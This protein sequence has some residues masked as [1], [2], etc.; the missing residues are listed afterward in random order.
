[1]SAVWIT[2]DT[3]DI[4][5]HVTTLELQ[6]VVTDYI[7]ETYGVSVKEVTDIERIELDPG[8]MAFFGEAAEYLEFELAGI[9]FRCQHV[10][11][12][13]VLSYL[14]NGYKVVDSPAGQLVKIYF[15]YSIVILP[16]HFL[17]ALKARVDFGREV[18]NEAREK[19]ARIL[20]EANARMSEK[21]KEDETIH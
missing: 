12:S 21:P 15:P 8:G 14:E 17:W 3:T 2:F 16:A 11:V 20:E 4:R 18:G 5:A 6:G 10:H 19:L 13:G 1:M 9:P 7:Q